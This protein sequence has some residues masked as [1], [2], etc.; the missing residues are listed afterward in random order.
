METLEI[1]KQLY[2]SLTKIALDKSILNSESDIFTMEDKYKWLRKEQLLKYLKSSDNE[3]F[4]NKLLTLNSL[5]M[6]KNSINMEELVMP[7]KLAIYNHKI[8]G[9]TMDYIKN[10]NVELLLKS[11]DI[12]VKGKRELL[13]S[14]GNVLEKLEKIRMDGIVK[15][16][17]LNDLHEGNFIYNLDTK[18]VN[19]V[20]LD[21]C[22]I[23]YNKP[24]LSRYLNK[25]S[26]VMDYPEKYIRNKETV[27]PGII[28]AHQHSDLYCYKIMVLNHLYQSNISFLSVKEYYVYLN[29]LR[30]LGYSYEALD[31]FYKMYEDGNNESIKPY[32]DE[33]P[34]DEETISRS[35]KI[36]Y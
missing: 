30:T 29:Y 21:S 16:F 1:S 28:V 9:F 11:P 36:R 10:I 8:I 26:N 3:N 22:R 33:F 31:V 15:N 14:V 24:F 32:I 27:F 17:Y 2:K 5:M 19:V 13:I 18:M 12:T 20:D 25:F 6:A 23:N 7:N 34:L 4:G 35:A